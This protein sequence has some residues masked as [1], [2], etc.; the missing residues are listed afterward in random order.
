[1]LLHV[2]AEHMPKVALGA[3]ALI[4]APFIGDGGWP[5][6]EIASRE[7]FGARL[8]ADLPVFLYHGTADDTVP[9]SHLALYAEAIPQAKAHRLAGCDHQLGNDLSPVARDLE[10]SA[11]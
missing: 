8:P 6:D 10:A 5:S 4:A 2:L 3:V 9:L 1:M 11:R 7:D